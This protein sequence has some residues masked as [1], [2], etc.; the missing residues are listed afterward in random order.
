MNRYATF[1]AS[2]VLLAHSSFCWAGTRPLKEDTPVTIVVG[3]FLDSS[4]AA[5]T[6]LTV[7]N[8]D[9]NLYKNDGTKVDVT[10]AGSG[11]SNDCVHVED[12]Y[13]SLELTATDTSTPR[14]WKKGSELICN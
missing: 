13:Y 11:T 10:L 6:A 2:L 3:P 8:I 14:E 4:G 7:S 1:A 5:Q 12:G 9:C